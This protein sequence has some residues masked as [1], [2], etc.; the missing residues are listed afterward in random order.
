MNHEH[1]AKIYG[2]INLYNPE[3]SIAENEK[4]LFSQHVPLFQ[5]RYREKTFF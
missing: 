4:K 5:V 1:L 2:L 3:I